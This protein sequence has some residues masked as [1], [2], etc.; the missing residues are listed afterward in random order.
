[1]ILLDVK[2]EIRPWLLNEGIA[3]KTIEDWLR[4]AH[5]EVGDYWHRKMLGRHWASGASAKYFYAQRS[6]K[7]LKAKIK[8]AKSGAALAGGRV[9]LLFS[10]VLRSSL[11]AWVQIKAFPSRVTVRMIGPKYVS[12]TPKKVGHPNMGK[13]ITTVTEDE[14]LE[15]TKLFVES[16]KRSMNN[17]WRLTA[18]FEN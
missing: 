8:A 12:M 1:M 18:V 15:L 2:A 11:K 3:R 10:G 13:E 4:N 16:M 14:R 7:Y 9:P 17:D 6:A 5:Q